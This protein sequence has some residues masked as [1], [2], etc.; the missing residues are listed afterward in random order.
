MENIKDIVEEV[1]KT[2]PT[3]IHDA[4]AYKIT[5]SIASTSTS[6]DAFEHR[7]SE[8]SVGDYSAG[9]SERTKIMLAVIKAKVIKS[10]EMIEHAPKKTIPKPEPSYVKRVLRYLIVEQFECME[11][12]EDWIVLFIVLLVVGMFPF[13]VLLIMLKLPLVLAMVLGFVVIPPVVLYHSVPVLEATGR[14]YDK[15]IKWLKED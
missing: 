12:T 15:C 7:M 2:I 11:A 4:D 14:A 13:L 6:L 5:T 3:E 9:E 1:L 10:V 8:Y